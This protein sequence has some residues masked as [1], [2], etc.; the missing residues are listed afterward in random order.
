MSTKLSAIDMPSRVDGVDF[1][2][3]TAFNNDWNHDICGNVTG[4]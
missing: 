3:S 1:T 4:F 2:L